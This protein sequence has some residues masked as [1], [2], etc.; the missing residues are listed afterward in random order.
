[1]TKHTPGPWWI[2]DRRV[3][4]GALQVQAQHRGEGSSYCVASV[5]GWEVPEANARLIAAAPELLAAL[6]EIED[7]HNETEDWREIA[8]SAIKKAKGL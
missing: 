2:D 7:H 4:D 5:N 8:R 3:A 1:M 6:L